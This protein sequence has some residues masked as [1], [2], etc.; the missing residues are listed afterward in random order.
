MTYGYVRVS[1]KE[2]NEDRQL[3]ALQKSGIAIDQ[4]FVDKKS[5]K[6]FNRPAWKRIRK[7]L[8][9]GDLLIVK[10]I[11]RF[12]RNY[13]EIINEWRYLTKKKGVHIKVIDMP[14][15]DTTAA[16]GLLAVFLSDLVLEILS[17]VA[18]TEREHI[19]ER[20]R[21]G[22]DAAMAR[23]VKFGRP[24]IEKPDCLDKIIEQVSAGE[25]SIADA[26]RTVGVSRTTFRRWAKQ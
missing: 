8:R 5:G 6:D 7:T 21:E 25:M 13:D 17:F 9:H 12:G 23:G 20:Q 3:I 26:A 22:I 14:L 16:H 15:L 10:S 2:Q 19:K 4:I 1:T 11:D 24:M 18:Q